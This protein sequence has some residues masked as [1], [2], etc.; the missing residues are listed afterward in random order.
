MIR[1]T[2]QA[3]I[4]WTSNPDF[5]AD[6]LATITQK[7]NTV[8]LWD[9]RSALLR[10]ITVLL[11][12]SGTCKDVDLFD[13]FRRAA[14]ALFKELDFTRPNLAI[15]DLVHPT[16]PSAEPYLHLLRTAAAS[17]ESANSIGLFFETKSLKAA[18]GLR[19]IIYQIIRVCLVEGKQKDAT[20]FLDFAYDNK[21][22]LFETAAVLLNYL[23]GLEKVHSERE[24]V[25]RKRKPTTEEIQTGVP[26][27]EFGHMVLS[28]QMME[29][30]RHIRRYTAVD[31]YRRRAE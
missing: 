18:E 25:P 22:E 1:C 16:R 2:V 10:L 12:R 21:P 30:I 11:N 27:D 13:R 31:G 24:V 14:Y 6:A 4:H 5:T 8:T 23:G 7:H 15:L 19:A 20:W 9:K 17:D 3:Q 26:V 28:P 29:K